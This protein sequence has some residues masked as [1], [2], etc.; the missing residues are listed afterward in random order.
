MLKLDLPGIHFFPRQN[1]RRKLSPERLI[2]HFQTSQQHKPYH[3]QNYQN[4]KLIQNKRVKLQIL[5]HKATQLQHNYTN[6]HCL[7]LAS[8]PKDCKLAIE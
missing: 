8:S 4:F 7:Q 3:R 6:Y 5:T 1:L 2:A